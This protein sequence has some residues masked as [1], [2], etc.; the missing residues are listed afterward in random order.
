MEWIHV[1]KKKTKIRIV[2]AIKE[3][4]SSGDTVVDLTSILRA[5][6]GLS[7]TTSIL[8]SVDDVE[9]KIKRNKAIKRVLAWRISTQDLVKAQR[10]IDLPEEYRISEESLQVIVRKMVFRNSVSCK[11]G[12]KE[13]KK[14]RKLQRLT[15][16]WLDD[17]YGIK[18]ASR[19]K[20]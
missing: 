9:R 11:E 18:I 17:E 8:K 16:K 20:D 4:M 15:K 10:N 14:Q 5:S 1:V 2:D 12:E 13:L 7:D 6:Q 19:M 3:S